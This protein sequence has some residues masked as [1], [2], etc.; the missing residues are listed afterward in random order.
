[1]ERA[2]ITLNLYPVTPVDDDPAVL[3]VA[4]RVDGLHNRLFLD[5]VLRGAYPEDVRVDLAGVT[6]FGFERPGD[7]AVIGTAIDLLGV[8]YYS[9]HRVTVSPLPGAAV[10]AT[11]APRGAATAMGWGVDASGLTEMLVRVRR[12]YGDIPLYVTENGAAYDDEPTDDGAV[13]DP[14]RTAYVAAHVEGCAAALAQGV[15][16]GGYFVW[17]L[18]DNF[19]WS[20]GYAKR[21]GIVH[22]DY[23]TQ[24]RRIKD[25]GRWYAGLIRAHGESLDAGP[26]Y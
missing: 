21:F 7:A 12:E 13:H 24:Q 20:H 15:P 19:E 11:M 8:N 4:R 10:A 22:V 26:G 18:L 16:L 5:P 3:D 6:D 1:V 25:S 23:A 9:R 17:S 2:G 14:E